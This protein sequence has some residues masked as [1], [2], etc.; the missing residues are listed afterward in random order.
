[1]TRKPAKSLKFSYH[2]TEEEKRV[3]DPAYKPRK[4]T[5]ATGVKFPMGAFLVADEEGN[6]YFGKID[7][8]TREMLSIC[9][10]ENK[11]P[12]EKSS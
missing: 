8:S 3:K 4:K 1:M 6:V 10:I 9:M 11:K 5:F 2:K 7:P 12:I